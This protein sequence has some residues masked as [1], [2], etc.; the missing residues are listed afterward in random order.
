MKATRI[1]NMTKLETPIGIFK[2]FLNNKEID[3]EPI[4]S[5]LGYYYND[6]D[7]KY[8]DKMYV[9]NLDLK[10]FK[11]GDVIVA[12]LLDA[13]FEYSSGDENTLTR[14]GINSEY[15][16]ALGASNDFDF[17]FTKG[18]GINVVTPD[19]PSFD[20]SKDIIVPFHLKNVLQDGYEFE[21]IDD[22]NKYPDYTIQFTLAYVKGTSKLDYDMISYCTC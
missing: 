8:P 21:I 12:L 1:L 2:I 5:K 16:F 3:F 10:Q 22:P 19:S 17:Y 6:N 4:E 11:K 15:T 20:F 9:I 13:N 18:Q 14:I 7:I